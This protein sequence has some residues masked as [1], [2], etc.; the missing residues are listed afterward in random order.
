[1][2]SKT[3]TAPALYKEVYARLIFRVVSAVLCMGFGMA[4]PWFV[5]PQGLALGLCAIWMALTT[6]HLHY[7]QL[8]WPAYTDLREHVNLHHTENAENDAVGILQE[9][10]ESDSV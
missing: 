5:S 8:L 3:C 2:K 10:L 9:L 6:F 7:A 1:M 4:V